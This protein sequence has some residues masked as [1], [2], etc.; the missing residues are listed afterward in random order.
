MNVNHEAATW[1]NNHSHQE[2]NIPHAQYLSFSS[3]Q[4]TTRRKKKRA[5]WKPAC[6]INLSFW[7]PHECLFLSRREIFLSFPEA[8]AWEPTRIDRYGRPH[9]GRD[10]FSNYLRLWG[11]L[12]HL[13]LDRCNSSSHVY[14]HVFK[15]QHDSSFRRDCDGVIFVKIEAQRSKVL[16]VSPPWDGSLLVGWLIIVQPADLLRGTWVS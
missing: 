9:L 16:S 5:Q 8:C 12:Q 6:Q 15:R 1:L 11:W 13:P 2:K 14:F 3:V 10:F 4:L 7:H